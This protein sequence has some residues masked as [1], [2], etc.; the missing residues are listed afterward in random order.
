MRRTTAVALAAISLSLSSAW[1][2]A[3]LTLSNGTVLSGSDLERTREGVYLL[4]RDGEVLAVPVELVKKIHL[5]GEDDAAPTGLRLAGAELLAG[6]V[7]EP[8]RAHEQLAAFGRPPA[9]F[10]VGAV[11]PYWTP[12]S[13]LGPDVSDFHPVRWFRAPTDPNWTPS[14]AFLASKDATEFSPVRWFQAPT[15]PVWRPTS[16]FRPASTWFSVEWERY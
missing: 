2:G 13:A 3:Q 10:R 11:D 12:V 4:S 6:D 7:V 5:T 14:S 16:G 15:N 8:P 1:G 9:S